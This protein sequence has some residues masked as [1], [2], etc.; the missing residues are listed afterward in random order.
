MNQSSVKSKTK[1]GEDELSKGGSI[2][3]DPILAISS[4]CE[5]L[6]SNRFLTLI[7]VEDWRCANRRFTFLNL[8]KF[9]NFTS[10]ISSKKDRP[11]LCRTNE[12]MLSCRTFS[13][14]NTFADQDQG[15]SGSRGFSL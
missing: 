12:G 15:S 3:I 13:L 5:I 4:S 2:V 10:K 6:S 14:W 8:F 11:Q 7:D 9:Q 1:Y